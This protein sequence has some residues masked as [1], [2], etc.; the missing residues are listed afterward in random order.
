MGRLIMAS[1]AT[2]H[3][4]RLLVSHQAMGIPSRSSIAMVMAARRKLTH[5]GDQSIMCQTYFIRFDQR[6][7]GV[8]LFE[9]ECVAGGAGYD[10]SYCWMY[11][12]A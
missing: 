1:T 11:G 7:N 8:I 2:F 3:R 5:K 4:A 12:R 10:R 9:G 6:Y